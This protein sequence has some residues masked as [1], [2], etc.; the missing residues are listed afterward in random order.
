[1][2][3]VNVDLKGFSERFYKKLCSARLH[4]VLETLDYIHNETDV[5]M[6]ITTLL[7]PDENDDSL[8]ISAQCQWILDHLGP[9]VPLHF[10]AFH[11]DWKMRDI[12]HTPIE[13]LTRARKIA[14][15]NGIHYAYTGNVHDSEGSS[16]W[17]PACGELLIE[18]DWYQLGR[19][20]LDENSSC[21][22]CGTR[23][24]GY[25]DARPGNFGPRRMPIR[26]GH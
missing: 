21:V 25:F 16:T 26:I 2:D 4:S 7:I 5:W 17:C 24:P 18:R 9:D 23:I 8:E 14:L 3:A 12:E 19:W 22:S 11:P 15:A 1:M 13:T 6:E 20:G 10:T